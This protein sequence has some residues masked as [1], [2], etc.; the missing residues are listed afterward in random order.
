MTRL[1]ARPTARRTTQAL[2]GGWLRQPIR[3]RRPRRIPGVLRKPTL[4]IRDLRLQPRDLTT[5]PLDHRSLL[6]HQRRELPIRRPTQVHITQFAA[7]PP[8]PTPPEQSPDAGGSRWIS[9]TKRLWWLK[10]SG[11]IV[12][13]SNRRSVARDQRWS[14]LCLTDRPPEGC[15]LP[16]MSYADTVAHR[17]GEQSHVK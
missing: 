13:P 3:G 5:Q 11:A 17:D 16:A 6:N 10:S 7:Q 14:G 12:N 9:P 2:R 15:G 1:P 8:T 4:Q